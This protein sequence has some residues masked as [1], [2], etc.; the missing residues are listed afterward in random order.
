MI[1]INKPR[2]IPRGATYCNDGCVW[3]ENGLCKLRKDLNS[4]KYEIAK[5]NALRDFYD[6]IEDGK[7]VSVVHGE[8]EKDGD[9]K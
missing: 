1:D 3:F 5:F 8:M 9:G 6:A 2:L 7:L 4:C